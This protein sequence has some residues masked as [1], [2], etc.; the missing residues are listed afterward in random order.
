MN[1]QCLREM[2]DTIQHSNLCVMGVPEGE[3]KGKGA[4]KNIQENNI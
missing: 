2:W 1:T 3:A 4:E